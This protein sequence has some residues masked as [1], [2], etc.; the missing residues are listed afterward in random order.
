MQKIRKSFRSTAKSHKK[1]TLIELVVIVTM[2]AVTGTLLSALDSNT[3]TQAK[4]IT[5]LDHLKKIGNI[6]QRY[7]DRYDERLVAYDTVVWKGKGQWGYR[8]IDSG[9]I[10]DIKTKW[11]QY[12]CPQSDYTN[13]PKKNLD[14]CFT[15]WGYGINSGWIVENGVLYNDRDTISPYLEGYKSSKQSGA[16]VRNHAE[17]PG[18]VILFADTAVGSKPEKGYYLIDLRNKGRGFR[19]AHKVNRCNVVFLD[20]HAIAA[21]KTKIAASGFPLSSDAT[22]GTIK[23]IKNLYW[24][25]SGGKFR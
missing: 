8:L 13:V 5:C 12:V 17:Q 6:T 21:D 1:F 11:K 15:N 18:N 4:Q 25:T 10:T 20:G 16:I 3:H 7:F 9:L 23:K 22:P 14:Y 19:D 2:I 24:Y